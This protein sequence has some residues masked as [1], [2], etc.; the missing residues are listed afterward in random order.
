MTTRPM[1]RNDLHGVDAYTRHKKLIKDYVLFYNQKAPSTT[2]A[3]Y[4]SEHD[5]IR[6]HHK[7]I[8]S[9]DDD[10]TEEPSWEQRVAKKYYDQ[11]FKEYAICDLKYYKEGKIALR[12]R[13]EKEVVS[14]KG[15]FVCASTRCDATSMLN[16]WEVN[17][18]YV[19][20]GIK[21]NELVKVR[22]CPECS[23]KL[24][25]KTQK[26]LAKAQ[27][28]QAKKR[29]RSSSVEEGESDHR[30][31]KRSRATS[32]DKQPLDHPED[33]TNEEQD[34][35]NQETKAKDEASSIW[36]QPISA[37]EEKSKEEEFEDY[38]ADLLQ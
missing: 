11:L 12:W 16:S 8:R 34:T 37:K 19:E 3:N 36:S 5:I 13:T 18:G 20:D 9:D 22:L 15:Q 35:R 6:E 28:Q 14:G 30:H 32:K 2:P 7:F 21:K 33:E 10:T 4:R 24:N 26:R 23:D 17:F 29:A 27:K 31:T 25:Y 1:F 38:F